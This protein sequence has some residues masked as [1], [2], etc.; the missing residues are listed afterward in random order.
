MTSYGP[1]TSLP[2]GTAY[3]GAAGGAAPAGMYQIPEG[4][5]TTTIYSFIR[6]G[7]YTDVIKLL[8]N[9]LN[10]FPESR[11]ILSLMAYC[12][13]ML[14]DFQEA[15]N[16]YEQLSKFHP[17]VDVYRLYHAQSLYKAGLYDEALKASA[18]VE[19]GEFG[20]K[21]LKLQAAIKYCTN[22][23]GEC[24]ILNEHSPAD[25]ADS[26]VNHASLLF[27][28]GKYEDACAQ[29]LDAMKM[30]G[31]QAEL[32]YYVALC[33]YMLKQYV[34]ALK[35]I[36]DII[37]RGIREHPELSVGMATEG[38]EVR[39]V[40][41]SQI[42]HETY[43]IEAFNLKA[44]IEYHLKNLDAAR[45]ALT[46]MPPRHEQELDPVTLH[47]QALMNMED[48]PTGGFEKLN[49]LLQQEPSPP[50]AFGNLLLLYIKYQYIDLAADLM[51]ENP[52]LASSTLEPYLYEFV[53]ATLLRQSSAEEAYNR[54]DDLATK[55]ADILRKLTRQV[56]EARQ[57]H[58]EEA[59]KRVVNEY[60][61]AVERYI[62][63]LMAQAKIYWDREN[64]HMVE[65]IFRKSVEFCNEHD[66]WK[67]N[68]AH[69][70]F[71]QE[72][73]YKE[74]ISFYEPIVKKQYDNILSVTAIVLANL[75]VSYIMTSQ[76]EEAEELMRKIE[77]EEERL[78]YDDPSKRTYHLCIV[79][80]VIGT[81]YCAKGNYEF[82]ISRIMKS[83]EPFNKKLGTDTWYYAKRCFTSLFEMLAKHMILLKDSVFQ[84]ALQFF[85]NCELHGRQIPTVVNPS[86]P[87]S[88]GTAAVGRPDAT[89]SARTRDAAKNNVSSE[90]RLLKSLYLRL[91]E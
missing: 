37:E 50:E 63:V 4:K 91:Y 86:A 69:V 7:R 77:K 46:D 62:P 38:I 84:E 49:F 78:A 42:L 60:D 24:K 25:D 34:P 2:P 26:I 79:N 1:R 27:K 40:G 66:I 35:Y 17:E 30:I 8:S 18:T 54:F 53:E 3:P 44:A 67:L 48:D 21:V 73:K 59:V 20:V 39:S 81:L 55:H 87:A 57:N 56:Q 12:Y 70:L 31:Y 74:A 13:F 80:L 5:S 85:D 6:D 10:S 19:T 28:E 64:Y 71:M 14:Q 41:N 88:P 9:E 29:Y 15:A 47:N 83:L 90:A 58:D 51:A 32:S 43:L 52:Q 76:N 72:S 89:S 68:V 36:A 82:G 45:E 22:D 33:H 16:C 75:C 61:D 11:P 23:L 65:K